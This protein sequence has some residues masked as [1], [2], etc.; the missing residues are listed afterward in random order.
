MTWSRLVC[1]QD[2]NVFL[3]LPL[4]VAFAAARSSAILCITAFS[5]WLLLVTVVN[6]VLGL[7]GSIASIHTMQWR[8]ARRL[9]GVSEERKGVTA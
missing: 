8:R 1:S 4:S 5:G 2:L 7:R 3:F 9:L 6:L